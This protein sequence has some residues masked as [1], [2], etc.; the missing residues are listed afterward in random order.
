[1]PDYTN[2]KDAKDAKTFICETCDFKCYK[3]SNYNK[4]LST[5]K[6]KLLINN[7]KLGINANKVYNCVCGKKYKHA[8]SLCHHKKICALID[9]CLCTLKSFCTKINL[10]MKII[11]N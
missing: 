7:G 6:H 9:L 4:H 1:M 8:S 3:L 2:T 11:L 5:S 10:Q